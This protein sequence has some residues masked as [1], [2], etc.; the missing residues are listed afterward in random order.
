M[1]RFLEQIYFR[2]PVSVQNAAVS[3]YGLKLRNERFGANSKEYLDQL[4]R[5]Q[6]L[7]AKE[8]EQL[9]IRE[10]RRLLA[11]AFATVAFHERTSKS[12]GLSPDDFSRLDDIRRLPFMTKDEIR[13]NPGFF[14]SNRLRNSSFKLFTSGTSGKPLT[15]YCDKN[16]RRRHYAFWQ[17]L[18]GWFGI[19]P[20]MK[21]ATFFG[22][23]IMRAGCTRPPFWR[24]DVSQKNYLFS[25]YHMSESNLRHY[26]NALLEIQPDELIGYPSSLFILA[27]YL[28]EK[29]LDGVHPHAV[30][31]TAETLLE[32]QR[33]LIEKVFQQE[34]ADQYGC[35]EMA[36]F[37]SQ[38]EKGTY[39]IHPEHG[40][41]EVLDPEGRPVAEGQ[42]GEAVC[43]GF[44][45]HAMPMIRYK[46]GD[47]LVLGTEKCACGRNFPVVKQILG[48]IDDILVT[49]DGRPLGRLDPVFKGASGIYE[50][51]IIQ[52]APDKLVLK[53]A[54]GASFS[55]RNKTNLLYELRKRIGAEMRIELE[56]VNEISKDKNGKFRSVISK[57]RPVA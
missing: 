29:K 57:I 48:R 5:N 20:G 6:Y 35:T 50:T 30:F 2:F 24:Y 13:A 53:I 52:P 27:R 15:I 41:V 12:R 55:D 16:S 49:P 17:R 43:T 10:L 45:N 1:N 21:R 38:C 33:E 19:R 9:Q 44:V 42:E 7:A 32:H 14:V 36:L 28:H 34:V 26:Y 11:H 25:S 37:V 39:H 22:R 8:L 31:T 56:L 18:R 51:Q 46:L 4:E 3:A 23:I 40:I 54:A 47:R